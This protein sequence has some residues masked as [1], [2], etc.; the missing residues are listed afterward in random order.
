MEL[1]ALY[2]KALKSVGQTRGLFECQACSRQTSVTAGTLFHNTR[3]PLRLWFEATWHITNQKYGA[4]ALGLQR[5]LGFL[6]NKLLAINLLMP[7]Q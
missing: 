6:L 5:V 7:R 1:S 2:V 4:N 3:K